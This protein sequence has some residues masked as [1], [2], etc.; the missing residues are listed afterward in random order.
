MLSIPKKKSYFH[1]TTQNKGTAFKALQ[2]KS[3]FWREYISRNRMS[4]WKE[5]WF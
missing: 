3:K 2:G 4:T 1:Q 5:R